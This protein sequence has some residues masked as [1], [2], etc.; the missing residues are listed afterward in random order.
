MSIDIL[1]EHFVALSK[2]WQEEAINFITNLSKLQAKKNREERYW[3]LIEKIDWQF[4]D[5]Y[6]AVMPL[7]MKSY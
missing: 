3:N 7:T 1:K 4:A 5:N 2:S 6:E